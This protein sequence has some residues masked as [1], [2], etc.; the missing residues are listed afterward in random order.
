MHI[1]FL[2]IY[3]LCDLVSTESSA[4]SNVIYN[5]N[6]SGQLIPPSLTHSGEMLGFGFLMV[7]VLADIIHHETTAI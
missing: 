2:S 4:V 3:Y 6:G 7:M 5:V 1:Y